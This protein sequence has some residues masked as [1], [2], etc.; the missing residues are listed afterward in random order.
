MKI[1]LD[2][3]LGKRGLES[4]TRAGHDVATVRGQN[5]TGSRDSDLIRVCHAEGRA[6]VTLDRGV[7]NPLVF[8]PAN[9]SGIA[10]LRLPR[11]PTPAQLQDA[12][13]TLVGALNNR[14]IDRKLW[15]VELGRIREY[16]PDEEEGC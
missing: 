15:I 3:N 13:R 8:D 12:I 10:V 6:L 14:A 2:E 16:Q 5:L 9:Y 4:L 11:S 7:A 1:K